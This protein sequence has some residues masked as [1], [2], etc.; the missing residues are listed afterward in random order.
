MDTPRS[1]SP[2]RLT[3][4]AKCSSEHDILAIS[5]QAVDST[6]PALK[7]VIG[8][9]RSLL[10]ACSEGGRAHNAPAALFIRRVFLL[11]GSRA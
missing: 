9:R 4:A 10:S 5:Y 8:K 2:K 6:V 11:I 1:T 7:Y 3:A